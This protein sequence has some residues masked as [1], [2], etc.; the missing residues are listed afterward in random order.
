M[1]PRTNHRVETDRTGGKQRTFSWTVHVPT[2][3]RSGTSTATSRQT[4]RPTSPRRSHGN[5][6]PVYHRAKH[7]LEVLPPEE[8]GLYPWR[9]GAAPRSRCTNSYYT[10][11]RARDAAGAA[12]PSQRSSRAPALDLMPPRLGETGVPRSDPAV[13]LG[14]SWSRVRCSFSAR[15]RRVDMLCLR[16]CTQRRQPRRRQV[17]A[18]RDALSSW[19]EVRR[20]V[21][22][23]PGPS[24]RARDRRRRSEAPPATSAPPLLL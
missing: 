2:P 3:T 13:L 12:A 1:P 16:F 20:P 9:T 15:G 11:A 8:E 19:R 18:R 6:P 23:R 5:R 22:R 21:P 4:T 7:P 17:C 10:P 24:T 14:W